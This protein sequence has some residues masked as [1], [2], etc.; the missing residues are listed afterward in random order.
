MSRQT[1]WYLGEKGIQD[2]QQSYADYYYFSQTS[3]ALI[4]WK[5]Q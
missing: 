3:R 1:H 5:E 4:E 2:R